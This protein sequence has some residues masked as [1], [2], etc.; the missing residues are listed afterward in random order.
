MEFF[1]D[2]FKKNIFFVQVRIKHFCC[3]NQEKKRFDNESVVSERALREIYLK[4]F[5]IA[6]KQGENVLIMT[7]YNLVNGYWSA[8]NYDINHTVLRDEWGFENFVMTD[9][10]TKCNTNEK[11]VGSKEFLQSM[12]RAENDIYMVAPDA[13]I[14]MKSIIDGLNQGYIT[15][16]ELQRSAKNILRWILK[17]NTFK[18]YFQNDCV[19]KYLIK[20]SDENMDIKYVIENPKKEAEYEVE[21]N[22]GM[23]ILNFSLLCDADS[24]AQN[25]I[26][27]KLGEI[28]FSF[29]VCGTEG[30]SVEIKRSITIDKADIYK[31]VISHA[32][33]IK[34]MDITI[35]Q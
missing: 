26:S 18:D 20:V 28:D 23:T 33:V 34:I 10:W 21:L 12:I 7:S 16:G 11:G 25:T 6:V 9:W 2:I 27:L 13:V 17:T 8:S 32:D 15:R 3:N 35:R 14:K 5:E 19:P 29:S 24:L 31:L 30:E 1:S 22:S 4:P